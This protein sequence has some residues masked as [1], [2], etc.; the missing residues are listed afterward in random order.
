M[1]PRRVAAM[2]EYCRERIRRRR[3][4]LPLVFIGKQLLKAV[5]PAGKTPGR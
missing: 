4:F 2:V 1:D 5:L 3:H